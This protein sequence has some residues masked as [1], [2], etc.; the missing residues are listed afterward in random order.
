M[1]IHNS[2]L[3]PMLEARGKA[4]VDLWIGAVSALATGTQ[5]A[6]NGK[7]CQGK[8]LSTFH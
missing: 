4:Q 2:I 1:P 7:I 3:S 5:N 6:H 8:F